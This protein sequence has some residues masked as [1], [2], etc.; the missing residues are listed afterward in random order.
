MY[1]WTR[2][3]YYYSIPF[4][5][6]K[7]CTLLIVAVPWQHLEQPAYTTPINISAIEDEIT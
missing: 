2:Y 7:Y 1:K 4:I 6:L 3:Y 5:K